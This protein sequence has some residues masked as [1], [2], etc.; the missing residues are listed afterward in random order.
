MVREVNNKVNVIVIG[1]GVIGSSLCYQLSKRGKSVILFEKEDLCSGT[2]GAC[3]AYITPHTKKP[4]FH[5]ALCLESQ[6]IYD[7]LEEELGEDLEYEKNRGGFQPCEDEIAYELVGKNAKDLLAGGLEVKMMGIDEVRKYEPALSPKL[8]GALHCPSAGQVNPFRVVFAYVKNA[9]R[10]G[11]QVMLHTE[12]LDIIRDGEKVAGVKTNKGDYYA[13]TIVNATGSWGAQIAKMA[14][15][16]VPIRPRRGQIVVSEAVP[17]LI[18]STMQSGMYMVIKHRPELISDERIKRLGCGYCIEQTKDGTI[19]I[20]FTREFVDF[21]K[22]TTMEGIEAIIK[23]GCKYIPALERLHFIR[24]FAGFRPFVPDG[25]PL[26]GAVDGLQGFFMAAG[27][28]GDGISLAPITGKLVAEIID[29]GT[30][31]FNID[32]FSPNRFKEVIFENPK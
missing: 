10:L 17:P 7:Q 22:R 14:G 23:E 9:K 18:H 13:D 5:L 30:S 16:N 11:T 27:H 28:E 6:K 31:S 26:I 25:L 32:A 2:S 8:V 3:D 24:T 20:G 1:G 12:V 19:L 15:F 21:D 29:E 4:G